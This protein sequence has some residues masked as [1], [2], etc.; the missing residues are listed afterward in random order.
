[1]SS[2]LVVGTGYSGSII[3]RKLAE[4]KNFKVKMIEQRSHIA[5]NMYDYFNEYGGLVHK[6]GPHLLNTNKY[7][8]MEFLEKYTELIPFEVKLLSHIDGNYVR[9]PFNFK[10]IQQLVGYKKSEKIINKLRDKYKNIQEVSI[11][12]LIKEEDVDI[13]EYGMLLY[14]KAYKTY[15]SKQW[16][17]D[18]F[19]LDESVLNRVKMRLNYEE[20]YLNTDFQFIP[21]Y[22]YTKLFENMLNHENI[23]IILNTNAIEH[24]TFDDIDNI[25]LYDGVKYDILVFTGAIDELFGEIYGSLPY[26]SLE[27]V[28]ESKKTNSILPTHILSCPSPD[29]AYTRIT[30]YNKINGQPQGEYS[31]IGIEYPYE[32]NKNAEKGNLPYYPIINEENLKLFNKYVEYSKKYKNL[33]LCGR[34][35]DYKYYNMDLII[36]MT[37]KKYKILEEILDNAK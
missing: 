16:G 7:E 17:T 29:V 28:Y 33:F 19:S 27:F 4:E 14:D 31:T 5:G 10:T 13:K 36:D 3:A 15:T 8:I 18:P 9:L 35:A 25:A 11:Y 34:L 21:K 6:Y 30:E 23:E 2:A 26:R 20:K 24:I 22:G 32:Y 12:D 1:M 37:L